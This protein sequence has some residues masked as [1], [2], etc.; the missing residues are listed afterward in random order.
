MFLRTLIL[1]A[2]A[3]VG[4]AAPALC[5]TVEDV[6]EV[7]QMVTDRSIRVLDRKVIHNSP[8]RPGGYE[9]MIVFIEG[10]TRYVLSYNG[11]ANHPELNERTALVVENLNGEPTPATFVKVVDYELDGTIDWGNYMKEV[12]T[13]DEVSNVDVKNEEFF[14]AMSN[15]Q[16]KT[17]WQRHYDEAIAAALRYRRNAQK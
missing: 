14:R 17:Y 10:G 8:R 1:T 16:E 4:F 6:R 7:A 13:S 5:A 9:T 11:N 2:V 12:E 3:T 15:T